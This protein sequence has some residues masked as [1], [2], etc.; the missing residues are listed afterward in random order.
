MTC[1][2]GDIVLI[3]FPF[4]DQKTS[5]KRPVLALTSPD[6][7]GDFIALAITSV[8]QPAP[9]ILIDTACLAQGHLPKPSWVRVDKI[10]TLEH[11]AILK[12]LAQLDMGTL[13]MVRAAL[14]QRVGYP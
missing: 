13:A 7:H 8:P 12:G 4:A 3:P 1:D 11:Q 5:K 6:L 14:C 10:F 2:P 9:Q